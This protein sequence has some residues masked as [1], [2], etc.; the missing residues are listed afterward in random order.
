MNR[1]SAL[2]T[3]RR[4]ALSACLAI[5]CINW[6]IP[7]QAQQNEPTAVTLPEVRVVA[8]SPVG[9]TSIALNK[10]PGNVQVISLSQVAA[11]GS[12]VTELLNQSIAAVNLNDTQGNSYVVDLNY[13]GFT[14]SP[15]LGTPQ[16]ISVFLDGMRMNEPFGDIMSWDLIPQIALANVTLIPGSNPVYGLN[17]L[18]GA[19]SMSTKSG[20]TSSGTSLKATVGSFGRTSLDMDYGAHGDNTAYY[21]ATSMDNE[22]GWAAHN[23]SQIRQVFGRLDFSDP[24]LDL[25]LSTMYS[26]NLMHGNQTVPLSMLSQ[27]AQGYSHPDYT[28]TQS[29]L[30]NLRG[31]FDWSDTQTVGGNV[32]SRHIA[33]DILNSNLNAFIGDPSSNTNDASC[34]SSPTSLG[35]PASNLLAHYTQDSFGANLQ[36]SDNSRVWGMPQ[37]AT[38]GLN[39]EYGRTQFGNAGQDAYVSSSAAIV[40]VTPFVTQATVGSINQRFGLFATDTLDLSKQL[41]LTG[42]ARYDQAR[43]KLTGSSCNDINGVLCDSAATLSNVPGTDTLANVA[44]A[45]AYHRLNPALGLTYEFSPA[46]N[47]F[48]NYSEGFRTPSAIE[49]MCADPSS[50]CNGVPNAFSSDPDL[51]A[52]VSKTY[53]LGLRGSVGNDVKWRAAAFRSVL[54]NDI[55]FNQT[56]ATQGYFSNV[57][58]TRRQGLELGLDGK[59]DRFDYALNASWVNA[60]FLSSFVIANG[61]NSV[62]ISTNGV[63]NGCAGVYAQPGNKI[64]GIAPLTFKLSLGYAVSDQSHLGLSVQA[65]SSQYARGDENNQDVHGQVPG[66]ASVKLDGTHKLSKGTS[67]FFGVSNVFNRQ[68]ANFGMLSTNQLTTGVDEQFRGVGAPR[69]I[70]AGVDARF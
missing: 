20:F 53:E 3:F 18:G 41:S 58:R 7:S 25:D 16:G 54:S 10:F 70:Y 62:C 49:L 28:A 29:F 38:V 40:G 19:I 31:K 4:N 60:S 67:L 45:H 33:R 6:V 2:P 48:A 1:Y 27:A 35:C 39:A 42:S 26:D 61:S 17:T 37:I 44:G 15:V 12:N 36:W 9:G 21:L 63:G 5:I 51:K 43:V 8:T 69:S 47:G 24:K 22:H 13:R 23:P 52:V 50:P 11:D 56:N 57:A 59:A 64:P 32:Y 66:F 55:L 14:A 68:Y 46:V 30:L 34:A 65:Q